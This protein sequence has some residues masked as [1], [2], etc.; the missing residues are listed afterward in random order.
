MF[1][2]ALLKL[3]FKWWMENIMLNKR[4]GQAKDNRSEEIHWS[5][6][7]PKTGRV[8]HN[9]ENMKNEQGHQVC[10]PSLKPSAAN[11]KSSPI[12]K[13]EMKYH[14]RNTTDT[15][16]VWS[17]HPHWTPSWVIWAYTSV[18][19]SYLSSSLVGRRTILIQYSK[20]THRKLLDK[21]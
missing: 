14:V 21:R 3:C 2:R 6:F 8:A 20:R 1:N 10:P 4:R 17:R 15:G 11:T 13:K 18:P 19:R 12:F 9:S 5:H 16:M 7:I